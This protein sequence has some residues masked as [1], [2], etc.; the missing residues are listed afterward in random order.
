MPKSPLIR[1]V[2]AAVA[3]CAI[4][5]TAASTIPAA[6]SGAAAKPK[7]P[8]RAYRA[9][10]YAHGQAMSILPPGENGLVTPAQLAGVRDL[11]RPGRRTARTSSAS[12][13]TC[14]T[15]TGTS[16]TGQL[17]KYYD[18]ESFGVRKKD[19]ARTESPSDASYPSGDVVIERDKLDIP[20]I[21]GATNE[22]ASFG[23]GYAQ[24]EDRLFLMDVLR[25]YGAGTLSTFIGPSCA[26]EQMDHDQ[27]LL[28]PYTA[29]QATAQVDRLP[30]EYGHA[31]PASP[32]R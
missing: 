5:A 4:A 22:A 28:A 1:A 17:G 9:H 23:A 18:D 31:G 32:S 30:K 16:R 25:H 12:T 14:S 3:C 24:A 8:S 27:L 21:Y 19:V 11:E 6:A 29:A 26:D 15:A 7:L 2:T 20:H 10:D 13:R